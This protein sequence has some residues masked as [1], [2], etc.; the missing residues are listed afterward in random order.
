M[1]DEKTHKLFVEN[2]KGRD[3]M[4]DPEINGRIILN[5]TLQK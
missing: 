1:G 5:W 3:R 4:G 2:L